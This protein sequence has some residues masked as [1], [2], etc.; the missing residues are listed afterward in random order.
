MITVIMTPIIEKMKRIILANLNGHKLSFKLSLPQQNQRERLFS[1]QIISQEKDP[2]MG[3]NGFEGVGPEWLLPQ[4]KE[5]LF[6]FWKKVRFEG[7]E[8]EI[9]LLVHA[10]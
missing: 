3:I 2:A 4:K 5:S 1:M 7:G 6:S 9:D 8:R 10:H